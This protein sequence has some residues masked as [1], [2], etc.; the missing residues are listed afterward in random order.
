MHRGLTAA[1][2]G[3]DSRAAHLPACTQVSGNVATVEIHTDAAVIVELQ[4]GLTLPLYDNGG[5]VA[6]TVPGAK[7]AHVFQL[8]PLPTESWWVFRA[9][10]PGGAPG[11]ADLFGAD[12]WVAVRSTFSR[13]GFDDSVGF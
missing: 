5:R 1:G 8:P 10:A 12:W 6:A 13:P 2:A 9:I 7:T 3:Q 11:G 4:Y